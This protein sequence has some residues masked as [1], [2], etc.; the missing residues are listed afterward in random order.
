[1]YIHLEASEL[2]FLTVWEPL[3]RKAHSLAIPGEHS[4]PHFVPFEWVDL[5]SE[6]TADS[7]QRHT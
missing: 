1:M 7:A 2:A 4:R 5:L 6:R 3:T